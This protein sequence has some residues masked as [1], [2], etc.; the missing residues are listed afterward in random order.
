M[1]SIHRCVSVNYDYRVQSAEQTDSKYLNFD[2]NF[3][4]TLKDDFN[5]DSNSEIDF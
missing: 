5:S 1:I 2:I 3:R 4:I